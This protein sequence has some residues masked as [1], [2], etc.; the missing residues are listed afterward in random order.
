MND[1]TD[2][3]IDSYYFLLH[4]YNAMERHEPRDPRR[5]HEQDR[6]MT[7]VRQELDEL[8]AQLGRNWQDDR[9]DEAFMRE[10]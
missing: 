4:E 9:K 10:Y 5:A 1:R 7:K 6:R 2:Q 3:L 8:A